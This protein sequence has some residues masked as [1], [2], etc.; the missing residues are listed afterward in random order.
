[1][2]YGFD[3]GRLGERL[4]VEEYLDFA[5]SRPEGERY[6]MDEGRVYAMASPD[7]EHQHIAGYLYHVFMGYLDGKQCV[8]YIAPFDV[9]L[10]LKSDP[11]RDDVETRKPAKARRG[12]GERRDYVFEPDVLVVC[13]KGKIK[14]KGRGH[15]V[16]G[17]PDFAAEV[18]SPS[19]VDMDYFVKTRAYMASGVKE[20]WIIDPERDTVAVYWKPDPEE[21]FSLF[22]YGMD[23]PVPMRLF[24]GLSVDFAKRSGD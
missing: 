20:Y 18:V 2:E 11:M 1:M 3:H 12:G 7:G 10:D 23:K 17:G 5:E 19:S 24:P 22:V 14:E 9:F 21:P 13:D 6:E 8:P 16:H 4:T 15:G